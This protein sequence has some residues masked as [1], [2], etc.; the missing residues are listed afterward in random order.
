MFGETFIQISSSRFREIPNNV[1][2]QQVQPHHLHQLCEFYEITFAGI[3]LSYRPL[4][5]MVEWKSC[6]SCLESVVLVE[7]DVVVG[8]ARYI[9]GTLDGQVKLVISDCPENFAKCIGFLFC[10]FDRAEKLKIP[11][12][13]ESSVIGGLEFQGTHRA[14]PPGMIA[15]LNP[16][17][18]AVT[19]YCTEVAVDG[20]RCGMVT[21]PIGYDVL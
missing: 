20:S 3:D 2:A 12:H 21:W 11:I 15:V 1:G 13:P 6:S 17:F 7:R 18:H 8:Y 10:K 5:K 4:P 9:K 19:R 14:I 16:E